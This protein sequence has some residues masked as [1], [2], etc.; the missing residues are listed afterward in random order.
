M[1]KISSQDAAFLSELVEREKFTLIPIHTN[2]T[3]MVRPRILVKEM[4]AAFLAAIAHV[5]P[6]RISKVNIASSYSTKELYFYGT[7]HPWGMHA[8]LDPKYSSAEMS[9][10][11]EDCHLTRLEK[12]GLIADWEFGFMLSASLQLPA[13]VLQKWHS[14]LWPVRQVHSN[15]ASADDIR[16]T[17]SMFN[18][19]GQGCHTGDDNTH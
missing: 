14:K 12:V 5:F 18:I 19:S 17:R 2:F 1:R 9:V 15:N 7:L 3:F 8:F 11:H 16:W 13:R 10:H 6:E 4:S